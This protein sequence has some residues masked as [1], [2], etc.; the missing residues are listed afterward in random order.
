MPSDEKMDALV[1]LALRER[2]ARLEQRVRYL[3]DRL[4]ATSRGRRF[5]WTTYSTGRSASYRR[6]RLSG[7]RRGCWW[8]AR[9]KASPPCFPRSAPA[10]SC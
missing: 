7:R 5:G 3:E 4:A 9:R 8:Y 1:A 6:K 10:G 2:L